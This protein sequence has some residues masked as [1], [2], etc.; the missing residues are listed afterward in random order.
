MSAIENVKYSMKRR[1]AIKQRRRKLYQQKQKQRAKESAEQV[2]KQK[3]AFQREQERQKEIQRLE[4]LEE[5]RNKHKPE[6]R[7]KNGKLYQLAVTEADLDDAEYVG[8]LFSATEEGE[9]VFE[10]AVKS[11]DDTSIESTADFASDFD[12]GDLSSD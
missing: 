4:Y 8:Q 1:A 5:L 6:E 7:D 10:W 2:E 3:I 12:D 11:L 9:M